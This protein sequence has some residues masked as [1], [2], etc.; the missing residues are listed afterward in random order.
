MAGAD[1]SG[2]RLPI[3]LLV[4]LAGLG[5]LG[6]AYPAIEMI[7]RFLL[8]AFPFAFILHFKRKMIGSL[9]LWSVIAI[10]LVIHIGLLLRFWTE[11]A[12]MNFWVWIVIIMGESFVVA[13]VVVR[14]APEI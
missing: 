10:L 6:A 14:F 2:P 1:K 8:S 13:L 5:A 11:I 3:W 7:I 9:R 4:I 12:R